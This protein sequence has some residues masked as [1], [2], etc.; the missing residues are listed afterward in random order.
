MIRYSTILLLFT[1]FC[2]FSP[3]PPRADAAELTFWTVDPLVKVFRD[4]KPETATEA[5]ADVARGEDATF[6]IVVRADEPI[7]NLRAEVGPLKLESDQKAVLGGAT[8]RFVGYVP[9]DRPMQQPPKDQLRKP[10]ADFPDPL[11]E[12]PSIDVPAGAAQPIWITLRVPA[13]P[14]PGLYRG[15]VRIAGKVA[16][17]DLTATAKLSLHVYN[18]AIGRT[19]LW[20]TNWFDMNWRH[21]KISPKPDSPEYWAL[22]RRYAR[23]MAAYRQNVVL[24]SP[25]NLA[26]YGVGPDGKLTIDFARFDKWVQIF[27]DEGVIGRIE[28]GHLGGRSGGWLS[29]FVL[30]IREVRDG[31]VVSR[32]AAPGSPEAERFC[33]A[34]LPALRDHLRKKGWLK[35]Y[36]QHIADE[37]VLLNA[38]SYR[39]IAQ[40]VRK[41]APE[42]RIIEANHSNL[43]TG[44]IDVWVPQLNYLHQDYAFYKQ[45]KKAGDEL[46][47]YTCIFPQGEYANRFIEQ[48]LIKTR[49][50]HWINFRYGATGYLHWGYN[51]WTDQNPYLHTTRPHSGPSYLPAGDAWIVYPGADGPIASI[52]EEAMRDGIVDYELLSMLVRGTP[53]PRSAWPP[54]SSWISTATTPT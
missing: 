35:Q 18:V 33:A 21:T 32:R 38:P 3:S 7:K 43:L 13:D 30:D 49:L 44:A 51:Q 12:Q 20:V 11:L 2:F 28:G 19:R 22:L 37:P 6:Q 50:L 5:A 10:P 47:F 17:R 46:W 24:I 8:V 23:N 16:G 40:L 34:F 36:M 45:R 52:R 42:L 39:A 54:R 53:R 15:T 4:A 41:Y 48:R 25:L 31:K 26:E 14:R 27:I 29:P 1:S 9:V